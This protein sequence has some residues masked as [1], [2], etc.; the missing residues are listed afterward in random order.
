ML[1]MPSQAF[2]VNFFCIHP[3]VSIFYCFN[4]INILDQSKLL[5]HSKNQPNRDGVAPECSSGLTIVNL[6]L[7][8]CTRHGNIISRVKKA[9]C[10]VAD[11]I[12]ININ[13]IKCNNSVFRAERKRNLIVMVL[14]CKDV[15]RTW[16]SSNISGFFG[17]YLYEPCIFLL[18][19][20]QPV[21][22]L[23]EI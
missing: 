16:I 21:I 11:C 1:R 14:T 23:R 19:N 15:I 10:G 4:I 17:V 22:I 6:V 9:L 12:C 3:V 18:Y 20:R 5:D 7:R 2:F 13:P 8:V